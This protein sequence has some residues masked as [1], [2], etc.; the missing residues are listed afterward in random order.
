MLSPGLIIV[1]IASSLILIAVGLPMA[2]GKVP[3]NPIYGVRLP[4]T[5]R[6]RAAW[7]AA[8]T[9]YGWWLIAAGAGSLPVILIIWAGGFG[10]PAIFVWLG[11]LV[12]PIL[13]GLPFTVKLAYRAERRERAEADRADDPDTPASDDRDSVPP[14]FSP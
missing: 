13:G 10:E 5:F 14:Q 9:H 7:D 12:V 1:L 8:N 11:V 6:S 3:P 4:V 2:L